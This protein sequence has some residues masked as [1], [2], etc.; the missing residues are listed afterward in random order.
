MF[1]SRLFSPAWSKISWCTLRQLD[2]PCIPSIIVNRPFAKSV[3]RIAY[4]YI[5]LPLGPPILELVVGAGTVFANNP[6]YIDSR[7]EWIY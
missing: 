7:S 3:S 2:R 4:R 6:K 1:R 5:C